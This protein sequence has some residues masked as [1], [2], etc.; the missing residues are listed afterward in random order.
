MTRQLLNRTLVFGACASLTLVMGCAALSWYAR[1]QAPD[2]S[3]SELVFSHKR[4]ADMDIECAACHS[5][6]VS[7]VAKDVLL[8]AEET[9]MACHS[10]AQGCELCHGNANM[11]APLQPRDYGLK[12]AHDTHVR[13]D[14]NPEGC[15]TCHASVA[16]STAVSDTHWIGPSDCQACHSDDM[17]KADSCGMCHAQ[18]ASAGFV[19]A[20]H[21][22][23]WLARHAS[24]AS[25]HPTLC[26]VC[27]RGGVRADFVGGPAAPQMVV[28]ADHSRRWPVNDCADCHMADVW[29]NTVHDA[30][31]LQSHPLDARFD[32]TTC[33]S[34]HAVDECRS[35]HAAAGFTYFEAHP[36]GFMFSH[37]AEARRELGACTAC[38]TENSCLAC[39][40]STSPHPAGW[41]LE[42]TDSN[43]GLCLQ[44]H[45]GEN[46]GRLD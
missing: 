1:S 11:V 34:C 40:Q 16:T 25:D 45:A 2:Q 3:S 18:M 31:Y 9:C 37:A 22:A 38:H 17:A 41:D 35:C 28:V 46:I 33:E 19:P 12:F 27:H 7:A 10:R 32:T 21:D 42:I 24:V 5:A 8:P 44:C 39:H 20:S 26:D 43:R 6:A 13:A 29:P 15:V 30:G 14:V 4:H 23:E 36:P